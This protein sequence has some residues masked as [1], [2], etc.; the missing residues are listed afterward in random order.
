MKKLLTLILISLPF[1][2][3]FPQQ[4]MQ[5]E[6]RTKGEVYFRFHVSNKTEVNLLSAII[7]IDK[8]RRDSVYAYANEREFAAFSAKGYT[9]EVL[10][11]PGDVKDVQMTDNAKNITAWDSYPTYDAYVT[12]MNAFQTNY[13]NLCQIY[14]AGTT[15]N[16]RKLLFARITNNV[17]A[18]QQGAKPEFMYSSSMHGDETTGYILM[19]QLIDSLL[20]TYGKNTRVT[21]LL[22]NVQLWINPLANPDGTYKSGNTTVNGAVRYNGNSVDLNRNFPDPQ[23]GQHPDGNAWQPETIA[24]MNLFASHHFVLS[25]NFH[26]GDEVV[27]Y[28]W[29][30]WA[31][32]HPDDSWYQTISKAYADT[33]HAN[34]PSG[35]MVGPDGFGN[36]VTN[37][38]T[39]YQVTGGR[40]DYMTYFMHGRE[41]TI[42]LCTT[43]LTTASK[44]PSYWYYNKASFF[45]YIENTYYG[46]RGT[47]QSAT[48]VPLKAK[49]TIQGHDTDNSEAYSDSV[50]GFF[51]RM[52]APGSYTVIVSADSFISQTF[53][54]VTVKSMTATPLNVTLQPSHPTICVTD[55]LSAGW[56]LVSI[57][58][59]AANMSAAALFPLATAPV[60][61]YSGTYSG[62]TTLQTGTGYWVKYPT[63]AVIQFCGTAGADTISLSQGWNLVGFSG[64]PVAA[65]S[66][67]TSPA[68]III[69]PFYTFKSA[70]V[71]AAMLQP[72]VGYWVRASQPGKITLIK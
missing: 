41:V 42:E 49:I 47:I 53:T 19:L 45:N 28:P 6:F 44:L 71:P 21:N 17:S 51:V 15:V 63:S 2:L 12:M 16:G 48:G 55:T 36:G 23:A 46:I 5:E 69:S 13:P 7:S 10:P 30:T 26:G 25:A 65:T 22:N 38:Y 20:S 11:H 33:V 1:A 8:V 43:K 52:I 29:D 60:Y 27:N 66:F 72:G 9:Y 59:Q 54:G 3:L 56:N 14:T 31:K 35:Y 32:L 39:W 50:T 18:L 34:S 68:N 61:T 64:G 24:M 4:N 62:A 58:A 40:Q 57:P 37:G 67:A 70:Y